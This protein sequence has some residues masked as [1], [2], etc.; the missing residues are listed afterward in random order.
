VPT[1]DV[2]DL[3]TTVPLWLVVALR[4]RA[5]PK[6]PGQW[7]LLG[8][9]TALSAGATL[10]L[11]VIEHALARLTGFHDAAILPKHLVVMLASM[12]VLGWVHSVVPPRE[13]EPAWYRWIGLKSRMIIF[14]VTGTAAAVAFPHAAQSITAPD[15]STDF[16]TPQYGN[17]AGTIHLTMYLVTIGVAQTMSAVLCLTA[18]RRTTS[19]LLRYCMGLMGAG[20]AVGVL[21]PIYRLSYLACGLLGWKYPLDEA[22]FHRGGSLMQLVCILLVLVGSSVR[23]ADMVM[24]SIR[25]R[26]GLIRIRP[27]WEEMASILPPDAVRK[28]FREGTSATDDRR[29]LGNLYGRLD[30]RV[31]AISDAAFELLPW[32]DDD[33]PR[34]AL[35]AAHSAGL[36]GA[37]CR[38]AREAIC[39]RVA[40]NKA[41]EG[42]PTA[43]RPAISLLSL[44]NDLQANAF[45]LAR[46]TDYYTDPR[47]A[48]AL[49]A[50]TS[51]TAF[52][53]VAV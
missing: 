51:P 6:T 3:L 39:L 11:T 8:T 42:E 14:V 49:K 9:F 41:V 25:Y 18:A 1:D 24:Q 20:S 53:E 2:I 48:E 43:E 27:L 10:R 22:Q 19:R 36:H 32:I 28:Y 16:A 40:R 45:W 50:F 13:P 30:N 33:L 7:A 37:D 31:V 46:V 52:Q 34:R 47:M 29:N 38:A 12:L 23:G 15:G 4:L 44:H 5:R 17:V 35:A 26:R 21:Y